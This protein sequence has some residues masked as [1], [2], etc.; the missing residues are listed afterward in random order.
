MSTTYNTIPDFQLISDVKSYTQ[1]NSLFN[2][3]LNNNW[4]YTVNQTRKHQACIYVYDEN[5][6]QRYQC[7]LSDREEYLKL[8][9][10]ISNIVKSSKKK[11]RA[12]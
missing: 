3:V 10:K 12:I 1:L 9:K 7:L 6:K 2:G 4:T 11:A 5:M 8:Q